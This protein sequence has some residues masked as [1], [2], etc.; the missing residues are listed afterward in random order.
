MDRPAIAHYLAGT[1]LPWRVIDDYDDVHEPLAA[2]P[3]AGRGG[4][5]R[6]P[7]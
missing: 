1:R 7:P 2:V 6:R 4:D 3:R 5:A